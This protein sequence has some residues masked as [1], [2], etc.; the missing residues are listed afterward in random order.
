MTPVSVRR[1]KPRDATGIGLVHV[2]SWQATY[3]GHFPQEF[4]D[5]LDPKQRAAKWRRYLKESSDDRARL[6]VT[7]QNR[8]I[9]GFANV[10]PCRDEQLTTAGEVRA[11]YLLPEYWDRGLGRELMAAGLDA[12]TSAG[13]PEAILWVLAANDRARRFYDAGGWIA[14]GAVK[15]DEGFGF[16]IRE[17]RYRRALPGEVRR[18]GYR[19]DTAWQPRTGPT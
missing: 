14:D 12:L 2:R 3:R 4:L 9:V 8:E 1:A 10:G 13:F 6:L 5:G 19:E 15:E 16:P 17:V 11:I 7:E 18:S